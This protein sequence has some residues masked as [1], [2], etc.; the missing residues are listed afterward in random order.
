MVALTE[1]VV[2]V[3]VTADQAILTASTTTITADSTLV[4]TDNDATE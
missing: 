4:T 2:T 3:Y 1:A